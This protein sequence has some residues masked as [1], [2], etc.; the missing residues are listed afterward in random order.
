VKLH[1]RQAVENGQ[2][3]CVGS[4]GRHTLSPAN[5]HIYLFSLSLWIDTWH[6]K[7]PVGIIAASECPNKKGKGILDA[8][9]SPRAE[10][11]HHIDEQIFFKKNKEIV[12]Q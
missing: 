4:N 1:L 11:S 10:F 3:F 12:V 8:D 5:G 2:S 7:V 6:S 9:V